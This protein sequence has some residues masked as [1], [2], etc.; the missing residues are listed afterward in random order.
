MTLNA[1]LRKTVPALRYYPSNN[2]E[3]TSKTI[4]GPKSEY[5]ASE[6]KIASRSF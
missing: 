5:L 2:L 4:K 3:E 1:E 6:P